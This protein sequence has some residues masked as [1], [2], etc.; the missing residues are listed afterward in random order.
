MNPNDYKGKQNYWKR[1]SREKARMVD[2]DEV[3]KNQNDCKAKSRTKAREEDY[4]KTR[5]VQ[6]DSSAKWRA[7]K[8]SENIELYKARHCKSL[9]MV[10]GRYQNSI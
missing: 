9:L 10:T 4:D 6:N 1:K 7:K 3:K 5:K 2:N 8:R